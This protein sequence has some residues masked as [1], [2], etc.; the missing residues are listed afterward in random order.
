MRETPM[1][2]SIQSLMKEGIAAHSVGDRTKAALLFSQA[3]PPEASKAGRV[4]I[5][6]IG[7]LVFFLAIK[8]GAKSPAGSPAS[9]PQPTAQ[10]AQVSVTTVSTEVSTVVPPTATP[11][12]TAEPTSDTTLYD[13]FQ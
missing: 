1:A 12:P 5:A 11:Q 6:V 9:T 10:R 3:L 8:G 4:I 7:I 2:R 13:A